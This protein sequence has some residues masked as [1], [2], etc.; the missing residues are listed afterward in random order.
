MM[1]MIV[2]VSFVWSCLR[3]VVDQIYGSDLEQFGS[4]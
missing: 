1:M 3:L 4:L 2:A